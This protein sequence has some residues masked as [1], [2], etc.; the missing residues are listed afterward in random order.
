M[1][2]CEYGIPKDNSIF[3]N[4]LKENCTFIRWCYNQQC[5]KNT[6][7]YINCKVRSE[8]MSKKDK[9]NDN[10]NIESTPNEEIKLD[11]D[12]ENFKEEY[13]HV[14]WKKTHAFG[15]EFQ[16]CGISIHVNE[17][18]VLDI[19]KIKDTIKIKYKGKIGTPS[20]EYHPVYD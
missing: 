12:S 3:C 19:D 15:I 17:K 5:V 13:C 10:I 2:I 20:F 16:N 11:L 7:G 1:N 4:E 14:L 9:K 18:H 8:L 6:D